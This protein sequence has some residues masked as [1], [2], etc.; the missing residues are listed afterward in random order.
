MI[1]PIPRWKFYTNLWTPLWPF[2]CIWTRNWLPMFSAT[3]LWCNLY[4]N[5]ILRNIQ[6]SGYFTWNMDNFLFSK[7]CWDIFVLQVL[8]FQIFITILGDNHSFSWLPL[9]YEFIFHYIMS[10]FLLN[11]I[12]SFFLLKSPECFSLEEDKPPDVYQTPIPSNLGKN[13]H[14]WE[15]NAADV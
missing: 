3:F 14:W 8:L 1:R 15:I 11:L 2:I 9:C 12:T 4:A 6:D 7:C 10:F 13:S 5:P